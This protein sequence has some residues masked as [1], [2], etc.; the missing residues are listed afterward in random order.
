MRISLRFSAPLAVALIGLGVILM[1]LSEKLT[2]SWFRQ[3]LRTRS[4]L[5]ASAFQQTLPDP[6]SL[7]STDG[8][9][10]QRIRKTIERITEDEKIIG[11]R[12]CAPTG[13]VQVATPE[14]PSD[15]DCATGRAA[16]KEVT[17]HVVNL[18][19]GRQTHRTSVRLHGQNLDD[20]GTL[21]VVHDMR[22][23]LVR[24]Q[25]AM[26]FLA[27]ALLLTTILIVSIGAVVARFTLRNW[28]RMVRQIVRGDFSGLRL[29]DQSKEWR[30]LRRDVEGLMR[31]MELDRRIRDEAQVSWSPQSLRQILKDDLSGEEVLIVSNREPYMHNRDKNGVVR[32]QVPASGLVTALEPIMRACSGTWIAHGSGNADRETVD[33]HDRV[34]V[35]PED[36]S[37]QIRRLWLSDAEEQGYY[38]GFSNEGLWPLCHIAHTRPTFRSEDYEYYKRVNQR[39]ADAVVEEAKSDDPVVLVQDYHFALL[40]RMIRERLPK[41]TILTFWHIPWTNPEAFGIC[42]WKNEILDGLLGSSIIGFHTRFHCNNFLDTVDRFLEARISRDDSTVRYGGKTTAV[43]SYPISI[44]W[45][46]RWVA[47]QPSIARCR[48]NVLKR[49]GLHE[50]IRIGIGVDR[51]D[52]TKGIMERFRAVERLFELKP[53]WR[54]KLCF[55]QIAAPSRSS[56]PQYQA[57]QQ[58]VVQLAETLNAKYGA[59]GAPAILLLAEHH[60]PREVF[61]YFRAADFCFV[62]SLHDGMNLVA[63]EFVAAREDERGVLILSQF[64]GASRELPE[65]LLV[66]PYHADQC[67][68]AVHYA[69][70]MPVDEQRNRMRAMRSIVQEFNVYR[71]AGRMLIDAARLRQRESLFGPGPT[72]RW[73]D[74]LQG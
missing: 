64:T 71:W 57:F 60:E 30:V 32:V 61:E 26:V 68:A 28:F 13:E 31:E 54:G 19:D 47:G 7:A 55:I 49:H 4:K 73:K 37:Y 27:G 46:S 44:E 45:P 2:E 63:K 51:M 25:K 8:E 22:F 10:I 33:R 48:E 21:I 6:F 36:P 5:I 72:W 18:A 9:A 29:S 40:P 15:E 12:Y 52:Y 3:D 41:A 59:P 14:M 74:I 1:P 58:E 53:E 38:Y 20:L 16:K 70:S 17:E 66:N 42:P 67:A 56:I 62:S 35:P 39:F 50:G 43:R 23:A 24:I 34:R 11:M 69:L 65:S